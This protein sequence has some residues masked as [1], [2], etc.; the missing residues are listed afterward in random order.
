MIS[1]KF[2]S[3][4]SRGFKKIFTGVSGRQGWLVTRLPGIPRPQLKNCGY[5]YIIDGIDTWA[6]GSLYKFGGWVVGIIQ[7]APRVLETLESPLGGWG[8]TAFLV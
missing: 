7:L 5:L 6:R 3:V 8:G 1:T 2:H 4:D